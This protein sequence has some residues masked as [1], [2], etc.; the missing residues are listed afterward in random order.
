MSEISYFCFSVWLKN[1]YW[2]KPILVSI[3]IFSVYRYTEHSY[4]GF[5][6][7]HTC[8]GQ[9]A[10]DW[11]SCLLLP[12]KIL[13]PVTCFF[14][15]AVAISCYYRLQA[16]GGFL[17][18]FILFNFIHVKTHD[19]SP[20]A[21]L[22]QCCSNNLLSGCVRTACSQLVDKLLQCC[23]LQQTCYN[24][25]QKLPTTCRQVASDNRVATW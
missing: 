13:N 23:W 9:M 2:Y 8:I 6:I 21:A 12:F 17:N 3:P 16:L 19:L 1:K 20:A 15:T 18:F 5:D 7:S 22:Y 11:N 24:L 25:F 4:L 10:S 14:L